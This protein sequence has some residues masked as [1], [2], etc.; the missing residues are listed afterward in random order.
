MLDKTYDIILQALGAA[1][2]DK[3][4]PVINIDDVSRV[5]NEAKLQ[6]VF[7]CIYP[8]LKNEFKK[9][10]SSEMYTQIENEFISCVA[11]NVRVNFEHNE[12][13]EVMRK[14]NIRYVILKGCSSSAYYGEPELRMMGDVDFL[15]KENDVSKAIKVLE[16]NGFKRDQYEF[17][18]NQSAYKRPPNSVWEIHKSVTGIPNNDVGKL[19]REMFSDIFETASLSNKDGLQYYVPSR[20][21]HG[22]ILLL[23]KA[24]H[25]TTG[26]LG[27]RHLCDWAVFVSKFNDREFCEIFEKRLKDIGLWRFAQIMTLLC[28]KYLYAPKSVWAAGCGVKDYELEDIM[29]DILSGGNFGQKDK[30]RY[31]EI[32]YITDRKEGKVG[33][34][35]LL[36]QLF[37]SLNYKVY[38]DYKFIDK[39]KIFLPVGWVLEAF[40]YLL[41]IIKGERKTNK[42]ISVIKDASERKKIYRKFNLFEV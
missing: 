41:L 1:L 22:L 25:M 23:H 21:N 10:L 40:S 42:S 11:N 2:F 24:S 36:L 26:G 35:N 33:N 29:N 13:D 12:L 30:N 32:K 17:T 31:R 34:N 5:I 28:E 3:K 20:F 18:T 27:L 39:Y 9:L 4:K 37:K 6:A 14:N 15:V 8:V 16:Q 19:I 38:A 7:T